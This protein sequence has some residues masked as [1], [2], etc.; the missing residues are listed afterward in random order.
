MFPSIERYFKNIAG[1]SICRY[2]Y[3]IYYW[4]SKGLTDEKI[5]SIKTSNHSI[6]P[7]LDYYGTKT[8]LEFNGSCLKQGSVTYNHE[9]IVNIYI[10]YEISKSINISNY[11]ALENCLFE[12]AVSLN[13][14]A[15]IDKYRYSGYGI[16]F[17]RKGSYSIGKE[18]GKNV[19]IFGADMISSSYIDNK[20]KDILILGKSP[21]QGLEDTLTAEKLYSINLLKKIQ[22]FVWAYIAME[23]IV[24]YLLMVQK[25]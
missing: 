17:D 20:K 2:V 14:N 9:K 10:V 21:T 13:K 5:N 24:I 12:A 18:V 6:T 25:L 1:V 11:P 15:G 19:I 7:N 23:Q 16:R 3:Y 22:S 8:K 4:E